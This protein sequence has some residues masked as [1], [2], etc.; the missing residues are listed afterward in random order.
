MIFSTR[1]VQKK[2]ILVPL[3]YFSSNNLADFPF[4]N[5]LYEKNY[6]K[7]IKRFSSSYIHILRKEYTIHCYYTPSIINWF[8]P[9]S[10]L[11]LTIEYCN[12]SKC[13]NV[14]FWA[15]MLICVHWIL[16]SDHKIGSD[17]IYP[18]TEVKGK[19]HSHVEGPDGLL[20]SLP[21]WHRQSAHVNMKTKIS[22]QCP[23][24]LGFFS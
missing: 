20:T 9:I 14:T 17:K 12:S 15:I 24:L 23:S 2:K 3:F 10:N 1:M 13:L 21:I 8:A 11:L 18:I 6:Q 22:L 16:H 5:R 19:C 4:K 7:N